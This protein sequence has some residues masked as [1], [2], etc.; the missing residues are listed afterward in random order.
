MV[1][2]LALL[3]AALALSACEVTEPDGFEPG[4]GMPIPLTVC[5]EF[6]SCF[7]GC[8]DLAVDAT[9]CTDNCPT[10]EEVDAEIAMC[11]STC[12]AEWSDVTDDERDQA[13]SL[14]L[15]RLDATSREE[16]EACGE[17]AS[18]SCDA[19]K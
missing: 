3:L 7:S 4:T 2:P 13:T 15:C 10:Q 8:L 16:R 19:D 17:M 14:S 5:E 6:G 12:A 1:R 18:A 11:D 9:V